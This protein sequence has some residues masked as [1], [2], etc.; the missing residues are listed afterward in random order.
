MTTHPYHDLGPMFDTG[1]R[2]LLSHTLICTDYNSSGPKSPS[3]STSE[4]KSCDEREGRQKVG[5][6]GVL[7]G[8]ELGFRSQMILILIL[9]LILIVRKKVGFGLVLR[10]DTLTTLPTA[11]STLLYSTLLYSSKVENSS[12]IVL[13]DSFLSK[14]MKVS[15][16][17][18][19]K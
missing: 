10:M 16:S 12:L 18:S 11:S 19:D 1:T 15:A 5:S 17:D 14:E 6:L 8:W 7:I 4:R 3:A 2:G 13:S 9:I